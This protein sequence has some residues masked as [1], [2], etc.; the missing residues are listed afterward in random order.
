MMNKK[1]E[2]KILLMQLKIQAFSPYNDGW[3]QEFYHKEYK[4]LLKKLKKGKKKL[5]D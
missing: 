2:Q 4:K 3:T 1:L 5:V